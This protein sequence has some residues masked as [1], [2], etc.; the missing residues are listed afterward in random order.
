MW[1]VADGKRVA[2]MS[3]GP[4]LCVAAS[5]NRRWIAAG[6]KGKVHV[7]DTTNYSL[8]L[9]DRTRAE[10]WTDAVDF[11]LDSIRLV[12]S[13]LD[14][15]A[16]VWDLVARRKI[17]T[18]EHSDQGVHAARYSPQGDRIVT[19]TDESIRV[20]DS[21]D[22]RLLVDINVGV[23]WGQ[24][25]LWC[26]THF[27]VLTTNG[28]IKE[29]NASTGLTVSEWTVPRSQNAGSNIALVPLHE[30]FIAH[31]AEKAITFWDIMTHT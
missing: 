19:A 29:I 15:L 6:S 10:D 20:W 21:N 8:V 26:K 30:K 4:V 7:W 24:N 17:R 22:S 9:G 18:L 5:R 1:Q 16:T 25:I 13:N 2:M 14:G 12:S 23:K 11:S 28:T 3:V 27:F 31:A